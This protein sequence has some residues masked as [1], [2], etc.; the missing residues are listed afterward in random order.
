[1]D[2]RSTKTVPATFS[3]THYVE[4]P[5][6]QYRNLNKLNNLLSNQLPKL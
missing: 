5:G 4:K 1:M 3:A 6:S 2:L